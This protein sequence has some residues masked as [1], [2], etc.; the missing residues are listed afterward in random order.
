MAPQKTKALILK[1]NPLRESSCI[2]YLLTPDHG[3]VHGV[4]KGVKQKKS[5]VPPLE[6]GF[7]IETLLYLRPHREL[8][9]LGGMAVLAYYPSIRTDLFKS[10]VRD[11]AFEVLVKTMSCDSSHPEVFSYMIDM[12][13]R[14]ETSPAEESFPSMVWRFFFQFS[15]L[16]GV[17]PDID[18]CSCCGRPVRDSD[19]AFLGLESGGAT[20]PGCTTADTDL[21]RRR[22]GSFLPPS[23]LRALRSRCVPEEMACCGNLPA[24]EIRRVTRLLARYCQYHF[25][26]VS[27]I[28]SLAFLDSMLPDTAPV[29]E[30]D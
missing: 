15:R 1:V 20:C 25:H 2:L 4:A 12:C 19:G 7:L 17:A 28:K 11:I 26:H 22:S 8:H 3:L 29:Y 30:H 21:R 18:T 14:M 10:V 23:V 5:G 13:D 6:R 9:T 24:D 16:M 27:D